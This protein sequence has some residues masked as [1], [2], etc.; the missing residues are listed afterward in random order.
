MA[1]GTW[2]LGTM[3][4][5]GGGFRVVMRVVM[6]AVFSYCDGGWP[7]GQKLEIQSVHFNRSVA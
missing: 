2:C 3:V 6:V 1:A 7:I 5:G 4:A